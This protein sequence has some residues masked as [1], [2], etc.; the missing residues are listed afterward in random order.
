M[1]L[2]DDLLR[3]AKAAAEYTGQSERAIYHMVETCRMPFR[4]VG[5]DLYFRKSELDRFFSSD[6]A[7]AA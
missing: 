3:G 7:A 5:R 2:A 4:R 1:K 6:Q